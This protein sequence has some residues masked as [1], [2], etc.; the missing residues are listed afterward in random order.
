MATRR[1][2]DGIEQQDE[3]AD[4]ISVTF[5]AV[6]APPAAPVATLPGPSLPPS[7]AF[8]ILTAKLNARTGAATYAE[9]WGPT[10]ARFGRRSS[11]EAGVRSLTTAGCW[12]C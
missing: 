4:E 7:N 1:H 6:P 5:D 3:A 11:T 10:S 2:G 9:A 12:R 8:S